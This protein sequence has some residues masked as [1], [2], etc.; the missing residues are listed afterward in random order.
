MSNRLKAI[1]VLAGIILAT[2]IISCSVSI[3][4]GGDGGDPSITFTV[5]NRTFTL[6][7]GTVGTFQAAPNTRT[8]NIADVRQQL[9]SRTPTDEPS[10]GE[11][12]L[13]SSS[14]EILDS[15]VTAKSTVAQQAISGRATLTIWIDQSGAA[16]PCSTGIEIGS[17][18]ITFE[19]G[20]VTSFDQSILL[21]PAALAL[22]L[23]ND[24]SICLQLEANVTAVI[25]IR[26]V[27]WVFGPP[28]E[29]D[30]DD[31]GGDDVMD[32]DS[33]DENDNASGNGNDNASDDSVNDNDDDSLNDNA[34]D[35][36]NAE[37][38]QND[39]VAPPPGVFARAAIRHRGSEQIA[40]GPNVIAADGLTTPAGY[41][42][43]KV[44]LSGDGSR[45]W[46]VLY[47]E[48][49]DVAG[50]P[51]T[52]LWSV[53]AD[54]S[55]G[56]RSSL[57]NNDLRNT[58]LS[59]ATNRDGTVAIADS[60]FSDSAVLR[61]SPGSAANLLFDTAVLGTGGCLRGD[62]RLTDDGARFYY[63]SFCDETLYRVDLGASSPMPERIIQASEIV[64]AQALAAR[65]LQQFDIDADGGTWVVESETLDPTMGNI[66]Y[67]N[68]LATGGVGTPARFELTPTDLLDLRDLHL[69]DNGTT[70]AYC[71]NPMTLGEMGNCYVQALGASTRTTI[72]D[73][74]TALGGMAFSDDGQRMYVRT[75]Y[76]FAGGCAYFQDVASGERIAGGTQ[77]FADN[78]CPAFLLPQLSEDGTVLASATA[79]GVY[80]LH[81]GVDGLPGFPSIESIWYR[82]E[83]E[84][85]LIVHV[86][87]A[88]PTPL[89]RI[90]LLPFT[91]EGLDPTAS[92]PFEENPFFNDR[93]G[94]GVNLNTT[95]TELEDAPGTWERRVQL[96][97]GSGLC[98]RGFINSGH[99][100]RV[101]V[102]DANGSKAVFQDFTPLP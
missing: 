91:E 84:S 29:G 42:V 34:G 63:R 71:Q 16:N 39:N 17:F 102:V 69:T 22:A 45:V 33:D 95:F 59:V 19:G 101:V 87:M 27:D 8:N 100:L 35:E 70:I 75:S 68:F 4:T 83:G 52:Q 20:V 36:D 77:R 51:L 31:D 54:G 24:F 9:F 37:D 61:A 55:G 49:P 32:D 53:N 23:T 62:V 65:A 1:C 46:F 6:T 26:E 25:V 73:G 66:L 7:L 28:R 97:D 98:K 47:D 80:V 86:I 82:Y 78:S 11:L 15:L 81:D 44:A 13:R 76:Q 88:S 40:A 3:N 2:V 18:N 85:E 99:R 14:V 79:R 94:G 60:G 56:L 12:R 43:I 89:E 90:F 92:A 21:S 30:H 96:C 57:N 10:S 93:S 72:T 50:D 64:N 74:R 48:F 67:L 38:N 5:A 41:T 58:L